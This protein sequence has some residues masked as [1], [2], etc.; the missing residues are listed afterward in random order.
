MKNLES[1]DKQNEGK[2][3][4]KSHS[5]FLWLLPVDNSECIAHSCTVI[6]LIP[7]LQMNELKL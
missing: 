4:A 3:Q 2:M 6:T 1:I 7:I 5:T